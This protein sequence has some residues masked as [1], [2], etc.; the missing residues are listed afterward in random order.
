MGWVVESGLEERPSTKPTESKFRV[1]GTEPHLGYFWTGSARESIETADFGRK[2][3]FHPIYGFF[4][5]QSSCDYRQ[6]GRKSR[7][8]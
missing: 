4:A 6:C 2:Q 5:W 7:T 8:F 3:T 1:K